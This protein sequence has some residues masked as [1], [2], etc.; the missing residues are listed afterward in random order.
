MSSKLSALRARSQ[1]F[2][3]V[4]VL[5]HLRD[6]EE[7]EGGQDDLDAEVVVYAALDVAANVDGDLATG[8][9]S[10]CGLLVRLGRQERLLVHLGHHLTGLLVVPGGWR[11]LHDVEGAA[12]Y[13][14][15]GR[16]RFY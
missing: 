8:R 7:V 3:Q 9:G 2:G 16:L 14:T 12:K 4:S 11:R 10:R 1:L 6:P 15:E 5:L 13:S